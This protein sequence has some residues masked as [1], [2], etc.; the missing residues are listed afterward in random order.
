MKDSLSEV[1][2]AKSVPVITFKGKGD[3]EIE[4]VPLRPKRDLRHITGKMEQLLRTENITDPDDFIYVTLT[5]EEIINDAMGIIQHYYPN[6]VKIEY[7]NS[8]TRELEDIDIGEIGEDKPF[9]ELIS[10]FYKKM[11]GKDISDEELEIMMS[12]AREAGVVHEA[13]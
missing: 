7:R 5:D 12:V 2:S 13:D 6:T 11:Y 9:D 3:M 4:L 1:N 10:E 8:H